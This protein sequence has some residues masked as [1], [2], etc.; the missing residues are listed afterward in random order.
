MVSDG[1]LLPTAILAHAT[2]P[3]SLGTIMMQL[4]LFQPGDSHRI[5]NVGLTSIF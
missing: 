5:T 2:D 3:T 1:V 4:I